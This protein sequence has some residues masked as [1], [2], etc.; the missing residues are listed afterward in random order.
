MLALEIDYICGIAKNIQVQNLLLI[1]GCSMLCIMSCTNMYNSRVIVKELES[2][3]G[4]NLC[5]EEINELAESAKK[6]YYAGKKEY[7]VFEDWG[8]MCGFNFLTSNLVP[9][10]TNCDFEYFKTKQGEG[11]TIITC[12][13]EEESMKNYVQMFEAAGFETTFES[14]LKRNKEVGFYKIRAQ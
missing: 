14:V 10:T 6:N 4:N 13:W 7:Y 12:C 2:N 8:F 9:Y 1:L 3:G 5:T 11:Y